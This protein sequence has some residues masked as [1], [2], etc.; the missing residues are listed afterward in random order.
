MFKRTTVILPAA[1]S[2]WEVW[3][4]GNGSSSVWQGSAESPLQG[5]NGSRSIVLALPARSCRTFA[6]SAP[7]ENREL[8]RKLAFAQVEK[9]GLTTVGVEQTPFECRVLE[10]GNGRSLVSVDVVMQETA[11]TLHGSKARAII[12]SARLFAIPEGKLVI[13]EEQGRLVLCAGS[14]GRLLHSQI[15]CATRELNGHA[16]PEIHMASLALRQQ[17]IL[18]EITGIELW[19]D[20]SPS[21]ARHVS[22]ELNLPVEIKARPAPD[23]PTMRREASTHLLPVA[24]RQALRRRR[25]GALRWVALAALILPLVLWVYGQR[26]KLNALEAQAARI[27]TTLNVPTESSGQKAEQERIRAEHELVT[28]AQARWGALRMALEPRRYPIAHL[29]GLSRCMTAADVVLTRFE[30][31]VSEVSVSGTARS[32]MDAYNYFNAVSKDGPLGVYGWSMLAPSIAA[33]GSASFEI[34]GK[35]R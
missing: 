32:A 35:M 20:F 29:D 21:N 3:R 24:A 26:K 16:T 8:L 25:L 30:S 34:K 23:S 6:F 2:H 5:A 15:V 12:P 33:D 4:C 13:I 19:G 17:G 14:G 1:E 27:E 18:R 10:Q 31:K 22:E 9:R 7:T 11:A 28:A